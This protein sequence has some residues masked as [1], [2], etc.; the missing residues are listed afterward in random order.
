MATAQSGVVS[1]LTPGI[2]TVRVGQ[3]DATCDVP[4]EVMSPLVDG[5]VRATVLDVRTGRPIPGVPVQL[6]MVTGTTFVAVTDPGGTVHFAE[7]GVDA[8][9]IDVSAFPQS[10]WNWA[11]YVRPGTADVVLFLEPRAETSPRE[12]TVTFDYRRSAPPRGDVKLGLASPSTP[13]RLSPRLDMVSLEGPPRL[14]DISIPSVSIDEQDIPWPSHLTEML[15]TEAIVREARLLFQD[16]AQGDACLGWVWGLAVQI[17]LNRFPLFGVPYQERGGLMWEWTALL[18][19]GYHV[20][21]PLAFHETETAVFRELNPVWPRTR[22]S[23]WRVPHL[24]HAPDGRVMTQILLLTGANVPGGGFIPLGF[25]AVSDGCETTERYQCRLS[26]GFDGVVS[27]ADNLATVV[28]DECAGLVAGDLALNWAPAHSGLEWSQ[29]VTVAMASDPTEEGR[30]ERSVSMLLAWGTRPTTDNVNS[31]PAQRFLAFPDATM[32]ASGVVVGRAAPGAHLHR[33]HLSGD[34]L[35]WVIT[36]QPGGTQFALEIP[37]TPPEVTPG[38]FGYAGVEAVQFP[39][40]VTMADVAGL[41][42]VRAGTWVEDAI[43]I[44]RTR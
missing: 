18:R 15:N 27:C 2:T 16:C 29:P 25:D 14:V 9:I 20:V 32:E 17:P 43:A 1:A 40:A 3:G 6:R 4:V 38:S 24:P 31:F 39:M 12:V 10:G 41:S 5:D 7:A 28:L 13:W 23:V 30:A 26:P 35:S 33:V 22:L 34:E 11:T 42:S 8:E 37:P 21:F 19:N 44:S 36:F